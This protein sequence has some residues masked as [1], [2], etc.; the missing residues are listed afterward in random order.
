MKRFWLT[1]V[2]FII[3][4]GVLIFG[5][6]EK[7]SQI[8]IPAMQGVLDL[9]MENIAKGNFILDGKWEFYW[10]ELLKPGDLPQY[11][12]A[13]ITVPN[14][15]NN[16]ELNGKSLS[17]IGY[18]TYKLK[19]ILPSHRPEMAIEIPDTYSCYILFINDKQ[20]AQNGRPAK[21][22]EAAIPF[23]TLKTVIL[24]SNTD[25]F[26]II[27]QVA[28][29]WH[30][31]GGIYKAPV[32]A[33][34]KTLLKQESI[35]WGLDV[36][37]AGCIFMSGLLFFG[38]YLFAR[39]DKSILFFSIFC[40]VY[41]YRIIGTEPY[42]LHSVFDGLSW[43]FTIRLEYISLALSVAFFVMYIRYLYPE[44]INIILIKVL[45][46]ICIIY[47]GIIAVFPAQLFTAIL[48]V[49]LVAMF[50][51]IGYAFYVFAKAST[52]NRSGSDYAFLSS[53]VA[54]ILF[55]VINLSYFGFI[56][57]LK[58]AITA[59]YI[60]F[61]F[62]QSLILSFRFSFR[63]RQAAIQA[64]QGLKAKS[65]FLSTI[66]HEIRTPLNAVIGMS[67]LLLHSHPR[68]D[69]KENIEALSFSAG[70]LMSLVNDILDFNKLEANQMKFEEIEMSLKD[71][72]EH[73]IRGQ[74]SFAHDKDLS[75]SYYADAII[76]DVVKGDPTR[77]TQVLNNLVHNAV[78]FT[79][80]GSVKL[81]LLH[82]KRDEKTVTV[83]FVIEDTGI[84]IPADKQNMI[85][86][87]F[88][89]ADSSTSRSYGG[90]GL[91][92]SI[93]KKILELQHTVLHLQSEE[94][95]GSTFW[96]EQTFPAVTNVKHAAPETF[97]GILDDK[98]LRGYTIL[99]VEDNAFNVMI[100]KS[101]LEE[102]GAKVDVATN[103]REAT[104]QFNAEF[105]KV[106]LMDLN[107]PVM[108]G[109]E[110]TRLIR[111][112]D[113]TVPII[114][115]TATTD[116]EVTSKANDIEFSAIIQKPFNPDTLCRTILKQLGKV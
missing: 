86:E 72:G 114:A 95:V 55:F 5:F 37:L 50:F 17:P 63:L 67:H 107:M 91:G 7:S 33:N 16:I 2:F 34:A 10:S 69:Q 60:L 54:L 15:W 68:E 83:K 28:N 8:D 106:I 64:R 109:Y 13:Y 79:K 49:Y 80:T 108:D 100:A 116:E 78:K 96:F 70:N 44:E 9:G 113:R 53:G 20:L 21:T 98:P 105:H 47:A 48:P 4:A 103:G 99:L 87:R 24:P 65:E 112:Q 6:K 104:E 45:F 39:H 46:W 25:T 56:Y 84:G 58:A 66:S 115:L 89:Q 40:L 35:D 11:Q 88:T 52:H 61:L 62:F 85:F 94:G 74:Q 38:L 92:L 97:S 75:I 81:S 12:P 76:P 51:Y 43:F 57:L 110:A 41:F 111:V 82:E 102:F 22:K 101:V 42:V 23:W 71:I 1:I 93:C 27:M 59:G 30:A 3:A 36:F 31:K 73:I 32:L 18:A 29:F 26:N 77:L 19:L 14:I 90:T